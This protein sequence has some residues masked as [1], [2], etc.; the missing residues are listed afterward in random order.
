MTSVRDR[1]K[2]KNH[3]FRLY[4]LKQYYVNELHV[5]IKPKHYE[6]LDLVI[7]IFDD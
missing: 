7:I 2:R 4:S 1:L 3:F 5:I 6:Y